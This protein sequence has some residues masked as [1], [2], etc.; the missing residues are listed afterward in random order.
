MSDRFLDKA[1]D[2]GADGDARPLYAAWSASYDAEIGENGYATPGR[3]AKAM[4]KFAPKA[5]H[6]TTTPILDFGCG[7]GL[8]GLA[9]RLQGFETIDGLDVTPEMI[10][11]ARGK[12]IYRTLTQVDPKTPPPVAKGTYAMITA[13]G[14]IGVGAAPIGTFDTIMGLLPRGGLFGFSFNDH[15]LADYR[16][17]GKLNEYVDCTAA[18]LLFREHGPHLP[19]IN[20]GATVYV[21][22]KL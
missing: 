9:L 14:V 8:S 10:D 6:S 11:I 19:G 22:E 18:R 17:E 12:N 15:A 4:A 20:L 7:T 3:I 21:L 2:L 1:Y 13:V 16:F 5:G